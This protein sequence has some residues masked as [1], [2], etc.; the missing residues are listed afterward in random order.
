MANWMDYFANPRSHWIK[1][2]MF[3]VLQAKYAQNEGIIDRLSAQLQTESD[4]NA[5]L[6][7]VADIYE[8]AYMKAVSDHREQ[9]AKMG[10]AAKVVPSNQ[11]AK[12]G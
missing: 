11:P 7:L 9:L 12:D 5:L 8:T 6:K 2:S 10:L 1:K 3:E 4:A